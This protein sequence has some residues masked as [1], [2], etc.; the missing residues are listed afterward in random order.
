MRCGP[1]S[2]IQFTI[3]PISATGTATVYF[4]V[5]ETSTYETMLNEG[6]TALLVPLTG[7]QVTYRVA[8]NAARIRVSSDNAADTFILAA[9]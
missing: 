3:I 6:G 1:Q 9:R 2:P 4:Q 8:L 7:G 5:P